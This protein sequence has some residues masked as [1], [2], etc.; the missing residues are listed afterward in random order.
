MNFVN[1]IIDKDNLL[2]S[3]K[4]E[5]ISQQFDKVISHQVTFVKFGTKWC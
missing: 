4:I 5:D 2:E 3:T 1:Q